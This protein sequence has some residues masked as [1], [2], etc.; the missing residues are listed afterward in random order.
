MT[1]P[2]TQRR[3]RFAETT[4][5][6][7]NVKQLNMQ[8]QCADLKLSHY[9]VI[10][11]Y[12]NPQFKRVRKG[13]EK[14]NKKVSQLYHLNAILKL[15]ATGSDLLA[16]SVLIQL[17]VPEFPKRISVKHKHEMQDCVNC[18]KNAGMTKTLN[19]AG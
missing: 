11:T 12:R 9:V 8:L 19:A 2:A 7:P 15:S 3:A 13:K 10:F 14:V 1:T 18:N 5:K 4:P 17:V 6:V 16:T